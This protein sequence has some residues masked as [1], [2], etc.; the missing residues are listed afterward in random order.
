MI[1][2]MKDK[3]VVKMIESPNTAKG[4]LFIMPSSRE[5]SLFAEIVAVNP[6]SSNKEIK[7]GDK[8]LVQKYGGQAFTEN[9]QKYIIYHQ[10]CVLGFVEGD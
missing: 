7:V 10:N 5:E 3:I 1:K 6:E 8:V 9:K 4:G 2:P